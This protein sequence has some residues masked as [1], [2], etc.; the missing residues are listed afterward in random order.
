MRQTHNN[1]MTLKQNISILSFDV[2]IRHLAY[3]LLTNVNTSKDEAATNKKYGHIEA[4]DMIDL[5]KVSSVEECAKKLSAELTSRFASMSMPPIDYVI[6]E[7]QPRARSI[8]MV[9]IQMYLCMYFSSPERANRVCFSSASRKLAMELV[10]FPRGKCMIEEEIPAPVAEGSSL[11]R[12]K[13][14]AKTPTAA[15][16]KYALNKSYAIDATRTYLEFMEDFGNMSLLE[17]YKKKDDLAD[18]FLQAVAFIENEGV[19]TKPQAAY[20]RRSSGSKA[21]KSPGGKKELKK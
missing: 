1:E 11:T 19:C 4:W 13:K 7:R 14:A 16:A 8:M 21:P 3:C 2:G 12:K 17:A 18:A 20:K 6:I 10:D 5:G 9:A 15:A